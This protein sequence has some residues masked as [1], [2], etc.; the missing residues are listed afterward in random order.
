MKSFEIVNTKSCHSFGTWEAKSAAEAL[1]AY[2]SDAGYQDFADACK[3][4]SGDDIEA[5]E[6]EVSVN[7][8]LCEKWLG[9][10]W[11]SSTSPAEAMRIATACQA[12][13][14]AG[15]SRDY[16]AILADVVG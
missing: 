3:V 15:D 2:A 5:R 1:D 12:K 6:V 10:D 9:R 11:P 4:A 16:T 13:R 8:D 7:D 14:N